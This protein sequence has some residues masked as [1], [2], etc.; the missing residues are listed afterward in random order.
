VRAASLW[1][2]LPLV[3]LGCQADDGAC[4]LH[5]CDVRQAACQAMASQAAACLLGQPPR[6]IPVALLPRTRLVA[7][8]VDEANQGDVPAQQRRLDALALL[9]LAD[10]GVTPQ[11]LAQARSARVGAFYDLETKGIT[12][13][14]DGDRA[15]DTVFDVSVLVHEFTHALQDAAGRLPFPLADGDTSYDRF[16]A[17]GVL[18]EGEASLTES[19]ATLTLYDRSP[20]KV[21]WTTLLPALQSLSE[22]YAAAAPVPL[23]LA[24]SYFAYPFGLSTMYRAYA[25]AGTAGLD[26]LWAEPPLSARQVMYQLATTAPNAGLD[27]P[28]VEDLA[29]QAVPVLAADMAYLEGDRQGAFVFKLALLRAEQRL[30]LGPLS[31]ASEQLVAGLRGDFFTYAGKVDNQGAL[32]VWRL[33]FATPE[34]ASLAAF[35]LPRL[36]SRWTVSPLGGRDLVLAAQTSGSPVFFTAEVGAWQAPPPVMPRFAPPGAAVCPVRDP[37]LPRAQ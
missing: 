13:V 9:F 8:A 18:V 17:R 11:E 25:A 5:A 28:I 19:L 1:P 30:R 35:H 24:Y 23:D 21:P 6:E 32:V 15:L 27:G 31:G 2:L 7:D 4:G 10:R 3:L 37:R 16:Q 34:L 12:I 20:G 36:S 33:R 29:D 14:T 26:R 22:R